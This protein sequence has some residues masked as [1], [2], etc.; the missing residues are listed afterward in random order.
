[1]SA[2]YKLFGTKRLH[3]LIE[4]NV[5]EYGF[6]EWGNGSISPLAS[7]IEETTHN[8]PTSR[9][10]HHFILNFTVLGEFNLDIFF[11]E[12]DGNIPVRIFQK[13]F[14]CK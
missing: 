1:M 13:S 14:C 5:F 2:N 4:P 12:K 8:L 3:G 10:G 7:S 6:F 11:I 9:Y